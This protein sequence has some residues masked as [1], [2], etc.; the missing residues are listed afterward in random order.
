MNNI[1][2]FDTETT[3]VPKNYKAPVTDLNNWPRVIQLAWLVADLDGNTLK[4]KEVLIKPNGWE[5]PKEPFWIKNGFDTAISLRDG[6]ELAEVLAEFVADLQG[7]AWMVAHNLAFDHPI[8]GAEMLRLGM[9]SERRPAK[10]CTMES[11][12]DLCKIP[13]G[14][15]RAYLSKKEKVYKWPKLSELHQFLFGKDFDGAHQA[16]A[17]VA[18][19]KVCLFELIR[20]GV[21]NLIPATT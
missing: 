13:F 21:I 3:G 4:T 8:V 5:I 6:L 14:G 20:R 9:K 12:I 10:V 16:G 19:V 18:A 1:M 17:D 15:E 11:T 7:C 2:I